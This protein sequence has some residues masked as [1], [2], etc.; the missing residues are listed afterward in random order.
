MS[1]SCAPRS[2]AAWSTI[3]GR[4]CAE[5]C[6]RTD[7]NIARGAGSMNYLERYRNGE[8]EQVWNEFQALGPL[9][10]QEPYYAQAQAVATETMRRVRR[11]CE[12]LVSRLQTLGYVFG[13]FPD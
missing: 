5:R 3:S 7:A 10:R 4:R 6:A 8:Y 13:T 11:N 1:A 2:C 12:R 9:V